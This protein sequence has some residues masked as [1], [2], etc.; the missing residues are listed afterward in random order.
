MSGSGPTVWGLFRRKVDAMA[1]ADEFGRRRRWMVRLASPL[2]ASTLAPKS[3]KKSQF[4]E[5]ETSA[6]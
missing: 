1:A 6:R 3:L 2:T 5:L 4:R